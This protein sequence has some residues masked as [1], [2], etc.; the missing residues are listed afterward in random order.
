LAAMSYPRAVRASSGRSRD[1]VKTQNP[2]VTVHPAHALRDAACLHNTTQPIRQILSKSDL[3]AA[4]A[5]QS[6]DVTNRNHS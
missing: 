4:H 2:E 5:V 1:W 3:N 6:P